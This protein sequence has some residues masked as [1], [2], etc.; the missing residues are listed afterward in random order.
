M[1]LKSFYE[2]FLKAPNATSLS[3]DASLHYVT[4][5]TTFNEAEAIEKHL[6]RQHKLAVK[7]KGEKILNVVEGLSSLC[8]D[9]EITLEFV[10][11]GGAYL[12]GLDDNF[13]TDKVV[14]LPMVSSRGP[15]HISILLTMKRYRF[16]LFNSKTARFIRSVSTGTKVLSSSSLM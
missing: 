1:S 3:S 8:L 16:T 5:L 7:K 9:V 12:P 13:L 4:T 2:S 11:G 10:T 14:T 15:L 6:S